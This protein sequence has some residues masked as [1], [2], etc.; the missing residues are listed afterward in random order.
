MSIRVYGVDTK[1][2]KSKNLQD[3]EKAIKQFAETSYKFYGSC[4]KNKKLLIKLLEKL[5]NLVFK[6]QENKPIYEYQDTLPCAWNSPMNGG[7][8]IN[9]IKWALIN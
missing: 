9:Y 5:G 7:W 3:K 4:G 1:E 6:N 2:M 8:K